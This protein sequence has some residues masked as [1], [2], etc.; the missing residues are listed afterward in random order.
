MPK[1]ACPDLTNKSGYWA[2]ALPDRSLEPNAVI[3]YY[4]SS[5]GEVH[6]G[7]N[8]GDLGVFFT[9]IDIRQ[10]LWAMIDLYGNCTSIELADSR[11]SMN[12]FSN[13]CLKVFLIDKVIINDLVDFEIILVNDYNFSD[14]HLQGHL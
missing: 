12:N 9:G 3:H 2:K 4:V 11:R 5:H 8:G 14:L 1:Y 7:I 13:R 10:P 6:F